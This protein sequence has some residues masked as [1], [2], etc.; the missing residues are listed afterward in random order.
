[1]GRTGQLSRL[2]GGDAVGSSAAPDNPPPTALGEG[3]R[4][5]QRTRV[6][7]PPP[8]RAFRARRGGVDADHRVHGAG[9]AARALGPARATE[10]TPWRC[11]DAGRGHG[12]RTEDR[13][14]TRPA[15]ASPLSFVDGSPWRLSMGL[16]RLEDG[17]WLEVDEH[18]G[19]RA[20]RARRACSTTARGTVLATLPTGDD[21]SREL[22]AATVVEHLV[23]HHDVLDVDRREAH[24]PHRRGTSIDRPRGTTRSRRPRGSPKRTCACSRATTRRGASW[25]R[26]SASRADGRCAT[27]SAA[28]LAGIHGPVP[29]FDAT[30]ADPAATFF[31]RLDRQRP[32]WRRNWT[33]L[34]TPELHL[35]SPAARRSRRPSLD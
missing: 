31:D 32:V 26:A 24:R 1:M 8:P 34:D 18:R 30:L 7:Y 15:P 12:H 10:G 19:R 17:A 9:P 22:L 33:L 28:T 27:S 11:E 2:R 23:A 16:H 20:A 21:P 29:G 3:P 14:V 25:R 5:S 6:R 13:V 35:P 4:R